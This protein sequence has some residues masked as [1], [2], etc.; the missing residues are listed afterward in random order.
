MAADLERAI[1]GLS[2]TPLDPYLG[3]AP[4]LDAVRAEDTGHLAEV[5]ED[6]TQIAEAEEDRTFLA[7]P[8]VEAPPKRAAPARVESKPSSPPPPAAQAEPPARPRQGVGGVV[9]WTLVLAVL[10]GAAF[11]GLSELDQAPGP[12]VV[13]LPADTV[14]APPREVEEPEPNPAVAAAVL[15]YQE[16]VRL[17]RLGQ[18][19]S[20]L[21]YFERAVSAAPQNPEYLQGRGVTLLRLGRPQEAVAAL[22]RTI[23]LDPGPSTPYFNLAEAQLALQDTAQA[24]RSIE[25]YLRR[26][27][28]LANRGI[29]QEWLNELRRATDPDATPLLGDPILDAPSGAGPPAGDSPPP[30]QPGN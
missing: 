26:E 17:L 29:A 28:D 6:R 21:V 18:Y 27:R 2:D 19:D 15:S 25:E 10:G 14:L 23:Q 5:D 8:P 1:R 16:G 22:N 20:A 24:I 11:W 9:V 7:P 30:S 4:I 3:G 12:M 13:D